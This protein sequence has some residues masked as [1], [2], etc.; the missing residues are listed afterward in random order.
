MKK[1]SI[2]HSP[3]RAQW[4]AS[5]I[6]SAPA[7]Y[8]FVLLVLVTVAISALAVYSPHAGAQNTRQQIQ[9]D[10][11]Q[12]FTGHEDLQIDPALMAQL[13]QGSGRITL[14]TPSRNFELQLRPNDL[15][16]AAYHAEETGPGGITHS[17]A[18]PVISTYEGNV[19]DSWG[20]DARL[21]ITNNMVEGMIVTSGETY[22]I[23]PAQ[24]FSTIAQP[25]DYVFYKASDV[26]ADITR[27]C[28]EPLDQAVKLGAKQMMSQANS[29]VTPAVFSPM[30]VVE[31]ATD[32]DFEYTKAL[33]SSAE[34]NGE[35]LSIMN[36]IDGIYKRDVGLTFTVTFQ[37]T[38][39]TPDPFGANGTG[40]TQVL[41]AFTDYWNA[42]FSATHRD[43]AHLWT[44]KN[45]GGPNGVAW[46]GV[47]C[48]NPAAAYG[49]S[50][51]ETIAPFRVG[52]P[53]HE[54][55]HNLG[56]DHCDGQAG[57]DN[58]IM[59]AVQNPS[60][61]LTFCS[62]SVNQITNYVN[63]NSGCLSNAPAGNP[64]DDTDF[65]VRQH[66][67]DFLGRVA[68][69]AGLNYWKSQITNCN[70]N[71]SCVEQQ[72]INVSASFF[73]SIEF[74]ETGYLVERTYKTAFGDANATSQWQ[75]THSI[76][77]PIVRFNEFLS[78]SRAIANG[79]VV[80]APNW[81]QTL[82]A[83]KVAYFNAFVQTSHFTRTYDAGMPAATFV[84]NLNVNAGNPLSS[85]EETQLA[86][87]LQSGAKTRARV[88]REIA[89]HPNLV[90]AEKNRAFVLMEYFGYLRRNPDDAPEA[91]RDYTGYDFWL[92]KLNQFNGDYF[93]AEMVK[94]FLSSIEYRQRFG[95]P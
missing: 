81:Q 4:S 52:I 89:E 28:A 91:S 84:H 38:W 83:N 8:V 71:A 19:V 9:Q 42:N 82:E 3:V 41:N 25:H 90:A 87:A 27:S 14:A 37:H 55:G 45:L 29:G 16:S 5:P 26:R 21:T 18:M 43:V 20:S 67:I 75:G 6:R 1:K 88:L 54:I 50:D 92:Q 40:A 49:I 66:Y 23:E 95:G 94:A 34:A 36:Q 70:A 68:D 22:Y 24:K 73:L 61:T 77:V 60:N 46:M 47:V 69:Q 86:S 56:A 17:V 80:G 31:I 2:S 93:A 13:A 63:A 44:G 72:R 85:S 76:K 10:L 33:G 32:A 51:R 64:I 74:Q 11:G 48:S 79:V 15:R 78:G 57:C 59:V 39:T 7:I 53:A 30:K 12:V 62:F 35:I 65:F 58:T